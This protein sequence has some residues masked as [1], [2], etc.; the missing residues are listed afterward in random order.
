MKMR[1]MGGG[2]RYLECHIVAGFTVGKSGKSTVLL[3]LKGLEATAGRS[4]V[5]SKQIG[6][7]PPCNMGW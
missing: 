3:P 7:K 6:R 4:P 5:F 1:I 2:V